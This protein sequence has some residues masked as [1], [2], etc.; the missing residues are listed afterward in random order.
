M[1]NLLQLT[2]VFIIL[3]S[4]AVLAQNTASIEGNWLGAID[5]GAVRLRIALKVSKSGDNF[6]AKFDS[7]D[8]GAADLEI[9]KITQKDKAVSFESKQYNFTY[10]GTLNEK[11]DEI[12]GT[13]RQGAGSAPLVFKRTAEVTKLSRPQ[14]PQ[15]PYPYNEEEVSYKN[16]KDNVKLAGTL[17]LP[18]GAGTFPAVIL[19]TGSGSQDRNETVAGHRPFLV[20]ADYLTRRGI[21]VLRVDDRGVGG[22][23]RG[24]ANFTSENFAED[25]LAGI[26]YLKSRKEINPKQIGLIGHSEGGMI[27]PM[28]AARSKDT[29]FIVLLA[30]LGQTGEDVIYTQTGL[31]QKVGGTSQFVIDETRKLLKTLMTIVKS[32][33]DAKR[34]EQSIDKALSEHSAQFTEEQK[35]EFAP[36]EDSIKA[37]KALYVSAW[38]RYFVL[39]N[40]R[41]TLE[42]VKIPVLALN[43]EN[44]VQVAWKENLDLIAAGLKAGGNKD[45]TVKSFPKLNHLFQTSQTGA[46]SEY[47]KIEETISPVVLETIADWI[48]KH[49][50]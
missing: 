45:V 13:F 30:G 48:L 2:F 24:A 29:A 16:T 14:D 21:A 49:T 12:N 28:V 11:G 10:E 42:K 37:R 8:Q 5:A 38:F 25:V 6:T 26:E 43:G 15:K 39:Y 41:P 35:K 19:I 22:T 23:E 9:D 34:V 27:A 17:T 18:R 46:V 32:E 4:S 47:D 31:G 3:C 33:T 7:I 50:K 1:K 36:V 40:P 44:D 20:L